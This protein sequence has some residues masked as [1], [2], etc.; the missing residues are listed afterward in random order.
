MVSVTN[1]LLLELN[2]T[3]TSFVGPES[4]FTCC[5]V[6]NSRSSLSSRLVLIQDVCHLPLFCEFLLI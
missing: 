1:K 2:Q 6:L 4:H 5:V 3:E